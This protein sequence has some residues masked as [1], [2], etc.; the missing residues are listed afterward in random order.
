M[1]LMT[2][3]RRPLCRSL[4]SARAAG[5]CGLEPASWRHTH[6]PVNECARLQ[7]PPVSGSCLFRLSRVACWQVKAT[8]WHAQ[9]NVLHVHRG[10]HE[11]SVARFRAALAPQA[12]ALCTGN[13]EKTPESNPEQSE[14]S[15]VPGQG[16]FKFKELVSTEPSRYCNVTHTCQVCSDRNGKL[17]RGAQCLLSQV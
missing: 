8:P 1:T 15:P 17:H 7:Q 4:L 9:G 2:C 3:L 6:T 11:R 14:A 16:L 10:G 13:T 5:V 12:R